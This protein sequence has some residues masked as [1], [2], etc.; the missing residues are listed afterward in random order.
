MMASSEDPD[1]SSPE[2]GSPETGGGCSISGAGRPETS[3]C[4]S[5][6]SLLI[7]VGISCSLTP[8]API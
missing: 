7:C 4:P 6:N 3:D 8:L 2:G 5:N 1:A